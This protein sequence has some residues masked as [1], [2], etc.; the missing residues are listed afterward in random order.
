M[1]VVELA[2]AGARCQADH[3]AF[4]TLTDQQSLI[5]GLQQRVE[6]LGVVREATQPDTEQ[7]MLGN[8]AYLN[9]TLPELAPTLGKRKHLIALARNKG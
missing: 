8:L 7:K 9:G 3:A 1:V 6:A 4:L 2:R 5:R